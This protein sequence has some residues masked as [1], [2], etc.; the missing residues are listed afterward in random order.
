MDDL[1]QE[2]KKVARQTQ[3]LAKEREIQEIRELIE[4]ATEKDFL[5]MKKM[6]LRIFEQNV[7]YQQLLENEFLERA[8]SAKFNF[9]PMI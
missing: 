5:T 3:R 1:A 4:G 2:F 8:I 9:P 7:L 6:M